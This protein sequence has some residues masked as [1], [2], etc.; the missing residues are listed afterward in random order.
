M[1]L[2]LRLVR[3]TGLLF[4]FVVAPVLAA[5]YP[6]KACS[7]AACDLPHDP[8]VCAEALPLP[9]EEMKKDPRNGLNRYEEKL[10][11]FLRNLCHR[12]PSWA[13]DKRIRNTGPYIA[14]LTG[15]SWQGQGHGVHP[16][17]VMYYSPEMFTWLERNRGARRPAQPEP[18]P[19]GAI[20]IK[21]MY[22]PPAE[23]HTGCIECLRPTPEGITLMVRDG[24]ASRDGWFWGWYGWPALQLD[25]PPPPSNALPNMGFAAYCLNCHASAESFSTFSALDNIAGQPGEPFNYLSQSFFTEKTLPTHHR[26]VALAADAVTR[27]GQPRHGYDPAMLAGFQLGTATPPSWDNVVKMP[28][29]AYDHVWTK[30]EKATGF[31]TSDQCVGCHDAGSTGLQFDMTVP[32]PYWLPQWRDKL[33]NLSPYGEW[34]SSPMGLAGRDPIFFAQLESEGAFHPQYAQTAQLVCLQCHGIMGQR[35]FNLEHDCDFTGQPFLRKFLDPASYATDF[36]PPARFAALSRDGISCQACHRYTMTRKVCDGLGLDQALCTAL[37]NTAPPDPAQNRCVQ[38]QR[39][40]ETTGLKGF[41]ETFVGNYPTM[42]PD[43]VIGPFPDPK[44]KPMEHALGLAPEH[45]ELMKQ[46]EVCGSCHT[47]YLPVFNDQGQCVKR[48]YEQ[49]TYPEWV[50]SAYRTSGYGS[51]EGAG[52]DPQSCQDCHMANHYDGTKITSKI[53]SIEEVSNFPQMAHTLPAEELDLQPRQDYARHTLVGLNV[54]FLEMAQQ[55]P[56]ILGIRTQDPM[57][58]ARGVPP[59]STLR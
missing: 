17:V 29:E 54:F 45:S 12:D 27:L 14:T 9:S 30:G 7:L 41:A 32:A 33:I 4:L 38:K 44:R 39:Q 23:R 21:E 35:Q 24:T 40:F 51:P 43:R 28:S 59:L 10:E 25:D 26:L 55:F 3:I 57:L 58:V 48:T 31:L 47:I 11:R 34:R 49:T 8:R 16:A 50:F 46:S 52:A 2:H 13:R 5:Q 18:I 36:D 53:A 19:D 42:A 37:E 15:S 1:L 6:D 20:I 22:S 56:D